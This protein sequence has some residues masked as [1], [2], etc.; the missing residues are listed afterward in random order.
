MGYKALI[1]TSLC[2]VNTLAILSYKKSYLQRNKQ[3]DYVYSSWKSRPECE[4]RI[5][6]LN[7]MLF[8]KNWLGGKKGRKK[9][10]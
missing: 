9:K 6:P 8:L 2:N 5:F 4:P 1:N 3:F 7:V 10:K